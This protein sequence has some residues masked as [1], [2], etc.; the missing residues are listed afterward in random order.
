MYKTVNKRY[1]KIPAKLADEIACNKLYVYIIFTYKYK[2][3]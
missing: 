3:K 2:G 1:D